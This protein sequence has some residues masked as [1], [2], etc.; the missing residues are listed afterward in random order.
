MQ[1]LTR[2][3][4]FPFSRRRMRADVDSELAFHIHSRI[5]EIMS[6]DGL[7][8]ADAE[9]EAT[10]RFGDVA[11]YRQQLRT[12]DRQTHLRQ[13]LSEYAQMLR[14]EAR[15]SLR[16]LRRSPSFS[17]IAV[18][19]LALGL[20]ACTAIFTVLDRVVLRPLSYPEAG[21]LISIGTKWP[22][23]RTGEEYGISSYMYFRF[24][25]SS[26]DLENLGVYETEVFALPAANGADAEKVTV[27]DASASL[28]PVL[29]IKAE[30]GRTF[31]TDDERPLD[32]SVILLSHM[33]WLRRFGGDRAIVGKTVDV[34]GRFMQVIGVLP[35]DATLP[36]RDG[37]IWAPLHLDSRELPQNNHVM[38]AIGLLKSNASIG[39]A[40]ADLSVLTQRITADFPQVYGEKFMRTTGFGLFVRSLHDEVIG[41]SV[42]RIL[43]VIFASVALVL[44]IAATNVAALFLIRMDVQRRE[45][46]MRAA[47]G[48]DRALI[49]LH[50]LSESLLLSAG[51]A[52]GALVFA[53]ALLHILLAFA[54]A[55]LPRLDEIALDTR[56]V[57]FCIAAAA[58]TGIAFGVLP[59]GRATL[60]V[61]ILRDGGR[62]LTSSRRQA[63]AR[64]ALVML[65]VALS[66]VLLVSA[67]L[68]A[69]SFA[70][71][72]AVRPGFAPAGVLTMS[73]SLRPDR[74]RSD[75][76]I[77]GMWRELSSRVAAL[78]GVHGTGGTSSLPL[79]TDAGCTTLLVEESESRAANHSPCVPI[80]FVSP[81]YF[82]TMRISVD[83][84][85][86]GWAENETG[87]GTMV[88]SKALAAQLWPG[89]NAIGKTLVFSQQRRLVFRVSGIAG[90]VRADGI[91]KPP[92]ATAYF[93]LAAPASAGVASR[94]D[95]DVNFLHFVVRSDSNDMRQLGTA[96][97]RA[98]AE[99]DPQLPVADFG[100]MESIVAKSM[101]QTTFTALVLAVAAV[102]ATLL[103]AVG[104]YGVISYTVVQRRSEI[105]I[106][107][108]LGARF[109]AIARV[110][111][112]QAITLAVVGAAIGLIVATLATRALR[113]LLYD[114]SPSDPTIAFGAVFALLGIAVLASYA[115]A[116]RAAAIDPAEAL[117]TE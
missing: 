80:V 105:G 11:D 108:A 73:I 44:A 63:T 70:K 113:S 30:L 62:G 9:A 18:L 24:R 32:T 5:E 92:S 51:A 110:V 96:I 19:T 43:W 23:I 38:H 69:K 20:G 60:D 101:A 40:Y 47:L 79:T 67:G 31:N 48:A 34:G 115:P 103:S 117:R 12:I 49:A 15:Q 99:I 107:M 65:Q 87:S 57:L 82:E 52:A 56:G 81:G 97:R 26:R 89:S 90:D 46:A 91:Q 64:R 53:E 14:R 37:D 102:I 114:V 29:G 25:E 55:S 72:R 66:V 41:P 71:L 50:C 7:S 88:V 35:A 54:P 83:G 74:Y 104:I 112:G 39:H 6:R 106:R 78:P 95:F 58:I 98:A 16:S 68:M 10:R 8:L 28:F 22:G 75:A 2:V 45:I 94:S 21:R 3:F 85:A 93:P 77:V 86:P 100:S 111:V 76:Q 17:V 61:A 84:E 4:R 1:K 116:R 33:I 42:A 109:L 59:L 27:V 13:Q 36:N